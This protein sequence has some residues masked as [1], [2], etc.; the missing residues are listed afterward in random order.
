MTQ[1]FDPAKL[2]RL[3]QSRRA[4]TRPQASISDCEQLRDTLNAILKDAAVPT[5]AP[6]TAVDTNVSPDRL[7]RGAS[8]VLQTHAY[9]C[10]K[11]YPRL[12]VLCGEELLALWSHYYRNEEP[13]TDLCAFTM[14]SIQLPASAPRGALGHIL[15]LYTVVHGAGASDHR[16]L[17]A[18]CWF[19]ELIGMF[20]TRSQSSWIGP[21]T[22]TLVGP[23]A[24]IAFDEVDLLKGLW[25]DDSTSEFHDPRTVLQ[26]ARLLQ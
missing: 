14:A 7:T 1:R 24:R 19:E 3:R 18:P 10:A 23:R 9:Y 13:N 5:P 26:T 8:Q 25:S 2:V 15:P 11:V 22:A 16:L 21:S 12:L 4:V 17:V 20:Y 6:T